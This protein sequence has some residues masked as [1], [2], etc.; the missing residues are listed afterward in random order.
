MDVPVPV[1]FRMSNKVPENI[2]NNAPSAIVNI[3]DIGA[4]TAALDRRR[5]AAFTRQSVGCADDSHI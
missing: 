2:A 1:V 3:D 4:G 5:D